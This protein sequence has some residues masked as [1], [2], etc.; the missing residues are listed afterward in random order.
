[1]P[2]M[3]RDERL[4]R[5]DRDHGSDEDTVFVLKSEGMTNTATYR[6]NTYHDSRE[7]PY[8]ARHDRAARDIS[9]EGAKGRWLGPCKICVLEEA[10]WQ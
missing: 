7:C 9:R 5:Q 10:D 4:S 1:M 3:T 2:N 6:I 8:F